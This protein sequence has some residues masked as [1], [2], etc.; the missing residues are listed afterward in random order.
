MVE[1]KAT[2][3]I[4]SILGEYIIDGDVKFA[5][6]NN[7]LNYYFKIHCGCQIY[8]IHLAYEFVDSYYKI[9]IE[10]I[11]HNEWEN[12]IFLT[13]SKVFHK[14]VKSIIKS[15]KLNNK[16]FLD[17]IT[18]FSIVLKNFT[19]IAGSFN[20]LIEMYPQDLKFDGYF[21]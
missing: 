8:S 17:H 20:E 9:L 4:I 16:S 1:N 13:R 5:P 7:W 15:N 21:V 10:D 2:Q 14:K 3:T 6:T 11:S 19:D 18:A 12:V